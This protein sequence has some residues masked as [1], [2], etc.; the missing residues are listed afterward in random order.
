MMF[1][2]SGVEIRIVPPSFNIRNASLKHEQPAFVG[3][4]FY[5][6]LAEHAVKEP[7]PE[8]K[9]LH[10]IKKNGFISGWF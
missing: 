2:T 10:Y 8:R 6:V 1:L 4:V 9:Q 5:H 7:I 3:Y